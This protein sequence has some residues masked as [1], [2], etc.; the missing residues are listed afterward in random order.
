MSLTQKLL[1][2]EDWENY[3]G[4]GI[5]DADEKLHSVIPADEILESLDA[6]LEAGTFHFQGT[7]SDSKTYF[8]APNPCLWLN[9]IGFIGLPLNDTQ[10]PKIAETLTPPGV[11][12]ERCVWRFP[13]DEVVIENPRWNDWLTQTVIPSL[14]C[15]LEISIPSGNIAQTSEISA[16]TLPKHR[17]PSLYHKQVNFTEDARHYGHMT[18][19]LPSRHSGGDIRST[20]KGQT[21]TFA[22]DPHDVTTTTVIGSYS[23]VVQ[24]VDHVQSGFVVSLHYELSCL[25]R[26]E[27]IPRFPDLDAE[28]EALHRV[29]K[30]WRRLLDNADA[31]TAVPHLLIYLFNDGEYES[32]FK[33]SDLTDDDS[34]I[35]IE[36]APFAKSYGFDLHF[37]IVEYTE[38]GTVDLGPDY[39]YNGRSDWEDLEEPDP[40]DLYMPDDSSI[41]LEVSDVSTPDGMPLS[42]AGPILDGIEGHRDSGQ[43]FI[44]EDIADGNRR[45]E[46]DWQE[47]DRGYLTYTYTRGALLITPESSSQLQFSVDKDIVDYACRRLSA[48]VSRAPTGKEQRLV[49]ALLEWMER[50]SLDTQGLSRVCSCLRQTADRWNDVELFLQVLDA[51]GTRVL[52]LVGVDGLCSGYQA[53]SWPQIQERYT[54]AFVN[55]SSNDVREIFLR[56][57][58]SVGDTTIE[59]WCNEQQATILATIQNLEIEEIDWAIDVLLSKS[60]PTQYL[61]DVFIPRLCAVQPSNL[62]VWKELLTRLQQFSRDSSSLFDEATIPQILADCIR[63][64]T[65]TICLY[66]TKMAKRNYY[67]PI[68][69]VHTVD[70]ILDLLDLCIHYNAPDAIGPFFCRMWEGHSIQ[71][72][73]NPERPAR[74]YYTSLIERLPTFFEG[75]PL[76]RDSCMVFFQHAFEVF[77]SSNTPN[78]SYIHK[79]LQNTANPIDT[80]KQWLTTE[81]LGEMNPS[82]IKDHAQWASDTLRPR[83]TTSESQAQLQEVL[84]SCLDR[85]VQVFDVSDVNYVFLRGNSRGIELL[86]LCFKLH[87]PH[88]VA[89]VLDK[90]WWP[91]QSKPNKHEYLKQKLVPFLKDLPDFLRRHQL[92][93]TQTPYSTF[94]CNLT[95]KFA[96]DIMGPKEQAGSTSQFTYRRSLTK[97]ELNQP[98]AKSILRSLGTVQDQMLILGEDYAWITGMIEGT[99]TRPYPSTVWEPSTT[100]T[101]GGSLKR[102]LDEVRFGVSGFSVPNPKKPRMD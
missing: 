64:I 41:T 4:R 36:I 70:P 39:Q 45:S 15:A 25:G 29:F 99:V 54:A 75:K 62:V 51:C 93:L 101:S 11:L 68:E 97:W 8:D 85:V 66:P 73:A 86:E 53:F 95:K 44:N 47:M 96:Q 40:D 6:A 14:H 88:R 34:L 58:R 59:T 38:S 46:F 74:D 21:K 71:T 94:A 28:N 55:E 77:R 60:N 50:N 32:R 9:G 3:V 100:S 24:T 5:D 23:P 63:Q 72:T 37:G 56:R 90:F 69:E 82:T 89:T 84:E 78:S 43:L 18:I 76:A 52:S 26:T 57:M 92:K 33:T 79:A 31:V 16:Y 42:I 30:S 10:P 12:E 35:L 98:E 80:L 49:E 48:S 7:F 67:G 19:V 87:L 22:T 83:A 1:D 17:A 27:S 61:R 102:S 91:V 65:T 20:Y 13:G 2:I 81:R